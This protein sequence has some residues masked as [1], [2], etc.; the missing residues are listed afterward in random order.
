MLNKVKYVKYQAEICLIHGCVGS[1]GQAHCLP[2]RLSNTHPQIPAKRRLVVR[3]AA[4]VI[5]EAIPGSWKTSSAL[6]LYI[7]L[8]NLYKFVRSPMLIKPAWRI[9]FQDVCITY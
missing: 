3:H 6:G 4:G 2:A 8:T 5:Q 1:A 9:Y 7:L